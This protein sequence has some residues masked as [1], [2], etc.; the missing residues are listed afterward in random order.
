MT[1]DEWRAFGQGLQ[2]IATAL[3][4][5]I[6]GCWVY[7]KYIHQQEKYPNVEFS[8]NIDFIG[9]KSNYWIVEITATIEN[10]GKAQHKMQLFEFDVNALYENDEVNVNVNWGGQVDFPNEVASGSFLPK[11]YNHFFVDPGT[12]AKYSYIARIPSEAKFLI[13]HCWFSYMDDRKYRHTAE[14]TVKVPEDTQHVEGEN[15]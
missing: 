15:G 7:R 14:K 4:F 12:K 1:I 2:G 5:L 3:S 13:L 8:A 10:K 6:G 11:N 9:K